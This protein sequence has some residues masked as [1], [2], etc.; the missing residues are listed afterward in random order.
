MDQIV[1][2]LKN[3]LVDLL[4]EARERLK[5][6]GENPYSN[7]EIKILETLVIFMVRAIEKGDMDMQ[8]LKTEIR[9]VSEGSLDELLSN[10]KGGKVTPQLIEVAKSLAPGKFKEIDSKGIS[11]AFFSGLTHDL[12][13]KGILDTEIRPMKK[14]QSF[15][16]VRF[17]PEQLKAREAYRKNNKSK[18]DK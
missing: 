10:R 3:T 11:Y 7:A 15:F 13:I 12:R 1:V 4:K 18:G 9:V 2:D 8:K 5:T 6:V 14:G 16:L 17:T